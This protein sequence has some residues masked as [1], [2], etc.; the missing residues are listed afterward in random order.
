MDTTHVLQSFLVTGHDACFSV[1]PSSAFR[2]SDVL[3]PYS[4]RL[5]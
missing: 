3:A 5:Q 1:F 2:L 4:L